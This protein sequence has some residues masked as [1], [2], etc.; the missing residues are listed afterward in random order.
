LRRWHT[1]R[2]VFGRMVYTPLV[3]VLS[4]RIYLVRF[5]STFR[6]NPSYVRMVAQGSR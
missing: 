3:T 2:S 5:L 4:E 6:T 1:Q